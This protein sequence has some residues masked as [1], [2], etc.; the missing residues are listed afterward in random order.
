MHPYREEGIL[1]GFKGDH[2]Y[3]VWIPSRRDIVRTSTAEF[4]ENEGY[5]GKITSTLF[6][7]REA[8]D[9]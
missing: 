2:I 3:R 4:H 6:I 1:V 5:Q 9:P 7:P 8:E